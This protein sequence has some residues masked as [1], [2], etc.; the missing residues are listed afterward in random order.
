[1]REVFV[2]TAGWA[3]YFVKNQPF[4][5]D[6]VAFVN[7][8]RAGGVPLVTTNYVLAEL[9]ALM[10][11]PLRVPRLQQIE[12]LK[13]IREAKGV[14]LVH[15]TEDIESATWELFCNRLDKESSWVDCAS[16]VVMT[17]H[18]IT[19]AITT[20]HHFEQAGFVRLLK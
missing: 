11:S 9:V 17:Q 15:I 14:H 16:F 10:I 20:D 12:I 8:C 19:E 18:G 4:H 6:A 3:C 7:L 2:D 5:A 13:A 1:M